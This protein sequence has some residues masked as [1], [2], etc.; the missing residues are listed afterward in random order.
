MTL[1]GGL[2]FSPLLEAGHNTSVTVGPGLEEAEVLTRVGPAL[3][4]GLLNE[5][6]DRGRAPQRGK[7]TRGFKSRGPR[8]GWKQERQC[9]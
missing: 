6:T 5:E 2:R 7:V 3:S 4:V 1:P 8:Q 9:S